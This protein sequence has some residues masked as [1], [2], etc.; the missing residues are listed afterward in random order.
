M[1][2]IAASP[3]R[4][5]FPPGPK[6]VPFLGSLREMREDPIA[7]MMRSMRQHGDVVGFRMGPKRAIFVAH[8]D[9]ARHVLQENHRNYD[10]ETP[11]F[12]KLRSL[13]GL[14][15]LTSEGD[16][17]LRQRRIAQPAFH[18]QRIASFASMMTRASEDTVS[19]WSQAS[20]GSEPL[21]LSAEMMRLTLRIAGETLLS[22]DVSGASDEVGEAL[23]VAMHVTNDRIT[24]VLDLTEV[25]PTPTNVRY[26]RARRT[27]DRIVLGMIDGRRR[28]GEDKGD[29]LSMLMLARDPETGEGMSDRQLR[30]EVMTIFLAG[31]ET[32]A[33]ALT[34]TWYLLAR[35]PEVERR[36][37]QELREVLGG[38]TPTLEDFPRLEYT[39][40]VLDEAM[41][42]YPP[43]WFLARRAV[44]PDEI[45]G[46][47][48]AP[49]T[50]L[51][52][53]PYA[54]HRHPDFWENPERFDPER[55]SEGRSV[56]RHRFAY[57]PFGGGP[58]LCIGNNF[59]LMEMRLV[60]A[61]LAQHFRL[62]LPSNAAAEPDPTITLRTRAPI[63]MKLHRLAA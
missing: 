43:A 4:P 24:R 19:R 30:D 61:T 32:T 53:S 56:G 54:T 21:D 2:T 35:H 47:R 6:G 16:F 51:M 40:M 62:S 55:F 33:N 15:L 38:R 27:L 57:F 8:P 23:T 49:G 28:S 13:L 52:I 29:L 3:S 50:L 17:W 20:S 9:H 12:Q 7:M 5:S 1:A 14:G 42:L 18:R 60:L 41:R 26:W 39:R 10:K 58:R 46:Y 44:G 34:W 11:G 63:R 45:A 31:H 36:L 37:H 59:A 25:L 48:I 22:A